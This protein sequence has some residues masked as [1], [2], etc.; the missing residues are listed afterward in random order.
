MDTSTSAKMRRKRKLAIPQSHPS[1]CPDDFD[2]SGQQIQS[3]FLAADECE[4]LDHWELPL[5][6]E[7]DRSAKVA[8]VGADGS[9]TPRP[10]KPS[11][12]RES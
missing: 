11:G 10:S 3:Q 4:L 8:N 1:F 6:T 5:W 7:C 9:R 12:E 2:G